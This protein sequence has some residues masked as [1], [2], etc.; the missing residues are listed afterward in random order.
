MKTN[1]AECSVQLPKLGC[2]PVGFYTFMQYFIHKVCFG[3]SLFE[4]HVRISHTAASVFYINSL[5]SLRRAHSCAE[6]GNGKAERSWESLMKAVLWLEA[7][8]RRKEEE[9]SAVL[10]Q[11]DLSSAYLTYT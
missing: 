4:V 8:R 11:L 9:A 7:E 10:S 2:L 6:A 1:T 5:F 3:L